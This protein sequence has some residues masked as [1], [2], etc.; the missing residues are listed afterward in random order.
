MQVFFYYVDNFL[1]ILSD[2]YDIM[3]IIMKMKKIFFIIISVISLIGYGFFVFAAAPSG[4]YMPGDTLDPD[5]NPGDTSPEPCIVQLPSGSSVTADNGLTMTGSNLQLGGILSQ[6][7]IIDTDA[8]VFMISNG[9]D[10]TRLEFSDLYGPGTT[11]AALKAEIPATAG[12]TIGVLNYGSGLFAG[13]EYNNIITNVS[14]GVTTDDNSARMTYNESSTGRY[15]SSYVGSFSASLNYSEDGW[16]PDQ[17]NNIFTNQN[18][19]TVRGSDPTSGDNMIWAVYDPSEGGNIRENAYLHNSG[20]WQW[21]SYLNTRDDS[22]INFPTNFLYTDGG[23]NVLSA[24]IS[25]LGGGSGWSLTGNSGTTA[26]TNFIGT[27]D[28]QDFVIKT[29][30]NQVALFGQNGN[31]AIGDNATATNNYAMSFGRFATAN[32]FG[33]LAFYGGI[34]DGALSVAM[35]DDAHRDEAFALR[36]DAYGEKSIA[37]GAPAYSYAELSTGFGPKSYAPNSE[38]SW[39]NA[40]RLF[41]IGNQPAF[42]TFHNAYTL[43]KDGSFAYND[44]NFQNDNP[45]TEQ[46]MF[47]FNYGNHDGLGGVNTKRAIRLG[48][49]TNDEWDINSGNVGNKSVAIGFSGARATGIGSIALGGWAYTDTLTAPVVIASGDGSFAWGGA[50]FAD[51]SSGVVEA[52]GVLSTAW[53]IANSA[54]GFGST[55]WGDSSTASGVFSTAWGS[56]TASGQRATSF[57]IGTNALGDSSTAFGFYNT[58]ASYSETSLGHNSTSYSALNTSEMSPNDRLFNIG[59]GDNDSGD[60]TPMGAWDN[61]SDAFTILKNGQ[62]GIAIDN[63]EANTNGN[64]FQIGD[65]TTNIIGYVDD[66]TGNWVAVSDERKK[67]NIIDLSYGLNELLQLRPTSFNYKRNREH[68]IGFI[69]QQVF[70]IIPEA[71]YGSESEGYGMSYATLT[72]VIVKAIQEMNLKITTINDMNMPNTWRDSLAAWFGNVS[73]GITKLFA[74]EIETKTLCVADAGGSK[75]CI[76]KSQLDQLLNN[77]SISSLVPNPALNTPGP[78]PTLDTDPGTDNTTTGNDT[79]PG[80]SDDTPAPSETPSDTGENQTVTPPADS[81]PSVDPGPT[82]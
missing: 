32:G 81:A 43:W 40:D 31:V 62:T 15:L 6:E 37:L 9:N 74:N 33:S 34:A 51:G 60:S 16:G 61:Q 47:Y 72:P 48:S 69:A 30:G 35:F 42:G 65:G 76:T 56:S 41:A 24:P 59:N 3:F 46:N 55:V 70:P 53:G 49:A 63:F 57:G 20:N 11:Y 36:A 77:A 5:C 71:V 13:M 58:A 21:L 8:N 22:G 23:G 52:S 44:D 7:T 75:T 68:T 64:I 19:V 2:I 78:T 26:G 80:A 28:P 73:N 1:F 25:S 4:G 45:G 82:E 10:G 67:D 54:E 17:G 14:T 66:I 50:K 39:D 12:A 29:N 38:T 18:G 79:E 27:T